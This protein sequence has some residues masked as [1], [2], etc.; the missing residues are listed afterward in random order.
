[1][2]GAGAARCWLLRIAALLQPERAVARPWMQLPGVEGLVAETDAVAAFLIEMQVEGDAGG[3]QRGGE[4]ERVLRLDSRVLRRL[5]D[6]TRRG[7]GGDVETRGEQA[8][9]LGRDGVAK[10]ARL[11]LGVRQI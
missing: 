7:R 11:A 8:L 1:M 3:A 2:L 10:E 5:P 6:E 9:E 4:G